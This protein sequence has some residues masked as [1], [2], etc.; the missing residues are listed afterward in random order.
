[1]I[2]PWGAEKCH[3]LYG[4]LSLAQFYILLKL[5][6]LLGL[7][8]QLFSEGLFPEADEQDEVLEEKAF[9]RRKLHIK[10]A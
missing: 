3:L 5:G 8:S 4:L 10:V 2:L 6:L 7:S 1:M 9:I